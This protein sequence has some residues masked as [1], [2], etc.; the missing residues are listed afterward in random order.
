MSDESKAAG[1]TAA[2]A[3]GRI[4]ELCAAILGH[5]A[6]AEQTITKEATAAL[7]HDLIF[8]PPKVAP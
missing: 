1:S 2:D 4:R 3:P 5:A 8:K 6:F 7:V